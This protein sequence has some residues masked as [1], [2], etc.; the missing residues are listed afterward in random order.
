MN[1]K[2]ILANV[3][4]IVEINLYDE[5]PFTDYEFVKSETIE[6]KKHWYSKKETIVI[7]AYYKYNGARCKNFEELKSVLES[8]INWYTYKP[9]SLIFKKNPDFKNLDD[10]EFLIFYKPYVEFIISTGKFINYEHISFDTYYEASE[11][12][13]QIKRQYKDIFLKINI[14]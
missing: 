14:K 6:I 3:N 4:H 10:L 13:S 2:E 1:R 9:D 7:P 8:S 12:V 5:R 11:F